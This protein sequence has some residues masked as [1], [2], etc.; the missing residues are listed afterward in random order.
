[1]CWRRW[2]GDPKRCFRCAVRPPDP[3][4]ART[5][6]LRPC[7]WRA[8]APGWKGLCSQAVHSRD[9]RGT[10]YVEFRRCKASDHG[11]VPPENPKGIRSGVP[12]PTAAAVGARCWR[13]RRVVWGPR[14]LRL[15]SGGGLF[16]SAVGV[17]GHARVGCVAS[18]PPS[19]RLPTSG[20]AAARGLRHA[21]QRM[22]GSGEVTLPEARIET[23]RRCGVGRRRMWVWSK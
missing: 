23:L 21:Q 3:P 19:A 15:S 22:W 17:R 8:A 6:R 11:P 14:P 5:K 13:P 4:F 10:R 9:V 20:A 16:A 7:D 1:M 2:R 18:T 12:G